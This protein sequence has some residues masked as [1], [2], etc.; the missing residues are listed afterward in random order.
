M[1]LR[2]LTILST[3]FF[4]IIGCKDKTQKGCTDPSATNY[5]V[6]ADEDDGS[7]LYSDS[8]ITLWSNGK[9]GVWGSNPA[10]GGIIVNSCHSQNYTILYNPD[11]IITLADTLIDTT[12]T[13]PDTTIIP[14]DTTISGTEYLLIAKDSTGEFKLSLNVINNVDGRPFGNGYLRFDALLPKNS[15]LQTFEVFIH[16]KNLIPNTTNLCPPIYESGSVNIS[17][18]SLDTV[19]RTITVPLTDFDSRY[20]QN[21]N[22]VFGIKGKLT[23]GSDTVLILNNIKWLQKLDE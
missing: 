8:T 23:S 7:C 14:A 11:T 19:F 20:L 15:E 4:F 16:G 2:Y 17:T 6:L 18:A 1:T 10:T 3:A 21:M 9:P 22:T 5:N 12:M 13:P